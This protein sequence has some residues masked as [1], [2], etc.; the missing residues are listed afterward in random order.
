MFSWEKQSLQILP[1]QLKRFCV[2]G[3]IDNVLIH[4]ITSFLRNGKEVTNPV[5][6]MTSLITLIFLMHPWHKSSSEHSSFFS[7]GWG[8]LRA[9]DCENTMG[10][11]LLLRLEL[12]E[13]EG[14]TSVGVVL[15]RLVLLDKVAWKSVEVVLL[16]LVLSDKDGPGVGVWLLRLALFE[17]KEEREKRL[18]STL[19]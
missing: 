14:S 17:R 9:V 19:R 3:R 5:S 16:R 13:R 8:F 2:L 12:L 11:V 10:A 15:L 18:S 4:Q 1:Q 6:V 7:I